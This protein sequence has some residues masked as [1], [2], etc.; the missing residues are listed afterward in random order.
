MDI[1]KVK[2]AL[3]AE[4]A[5]LEGLNNEEWCNEDITG[6]PKLSIPFN[7]MNKDHVKNVL[8]PSNEMVHEV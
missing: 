2:E 5:R 1:Y 8:V 7:K 4:I 3:D 6:F